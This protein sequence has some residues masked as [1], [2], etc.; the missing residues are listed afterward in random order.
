MAKILALAFLHPELSGRAV[1]VM[2][3]T[4]PILGS[5]CHGALCTPF[6]PA[7]PACSRPSMAGL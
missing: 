1:S 6:S 7:P 4:P 3:A 2:P 5:G